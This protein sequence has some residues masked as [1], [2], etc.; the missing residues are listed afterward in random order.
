MIEPKKI[1]ELLDHLSGSICFKDLDKV[2]VMA[3]SND[4]TLQMVC[5]GPDV[6]AAVGVMFDKIKTG[7]AVIASRL[8]IV[9]SGQRAQ[10][11]IELE[12][13]RG[14]E[15]DPKVIVVAAL[16]ERTTRQLKVVD[17]TFKGD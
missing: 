17:P 11:K 2:R 10:Y 1:L 6:E 15:E 16:I 12:K 7:R 8:R 14:N 13:A 5:Y 9:L 3:F 4:R